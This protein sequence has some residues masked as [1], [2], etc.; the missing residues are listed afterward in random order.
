MR[1]K[2]RVD[3]RELKEKAQ[4][5]REQTLEYSYGVPHHLGGSLS[6]IEILT[7]LYYGIMGGKNA[8]AP[9]CPKFVLSKG[10]ACIP[11][12]IILADLGLIEVQELKRIMSMGGRLLGHPCR[13]TTPGI[14]VSTGSLGQGLSFAVGMG[15][16]LRRLR[17]CTNVYA[18][19]SD[20]EL[21]SGQTWEALLFLSQHR[22][23]N[24]HVVIDYN[25]FQA[26]G[27]L[28]KIVS[29]D[30]LSDKLEA[31]GFCV[32]ECDGHDLEQ[33][34]AFL[35]RDT[36]ERVAILIAHTIK[37]KG[38]SFME[39][40]N[41]WHSGTFGKDAYEQAVQELSKSRSRPAARGLVAALSLLAEAVLK[42]AT[43]LSEE[44]VA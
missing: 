2:E 1:A 35:Q 34:L 22:L 15:F 29:L 16:G 4:W 14:D 23:N 24:V 11:L 39:N 40:N 42:S 25:G 8:R 37:G 32:E 17:A 28:S 43:R 21:Q 19:L 27:P 33:L 20:G 30:P 9:G 5:L 3:I 36:Q 6:C 41:S 18:L 7:A 38:V 44:L 26:D 10:H 13:T 12:Y 31:L